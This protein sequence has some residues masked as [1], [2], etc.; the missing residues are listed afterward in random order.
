MKLHAQNLV[1]NN[2]ELLMKINELLN[3]VDWSTLDYHQVQYMLDIID[4]CHLTAVCE[5]AERKYRGKWRGE[6]E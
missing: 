5:M 1:D 4:D 6:T 2:D 3:I